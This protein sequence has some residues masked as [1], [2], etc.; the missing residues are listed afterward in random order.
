MKTIQVYLSMMSLLVLTACGGESGEAKKLGF[1]SVDEMK[2]L[3][4]QGWHTK[5]RYEEDAAKKL[6]YLSAAEWR[7]AEIKIKKEKEF[8]RNWKTKG[9]YVVAVG[10][11]TPNHRLAETAMMTLMLSGEDAFKRLIKSTWA[12]QNIVCASYPASFKGVKLNFDGPVK[13]LGRKGNIVYWYMET[14]DEG[15]SGAL[16]GYT[17]YEE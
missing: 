2:E 10:C 12:G 11:L 9:R 13:V 3:H 1:A 4:A 16:G 14:A 6:G 8:E 7:A 17:T 15:G 5:E